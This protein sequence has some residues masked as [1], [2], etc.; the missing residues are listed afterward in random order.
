MNGTFSLKRF[1]RLFVKHTREHYKGYLMSLSV[2]IGVML[3]GGGFLVYMVN[4]RLDKGV[5]TVFF[6]MILLLAGSIFTSTVF[7][8]L[9]ERK[10]AIV[11]LTLP[12]S[13]FEKFLIAWIYSFIVF[14]V[15]YTIS[16]YCVAMFILNIKRFNEQP[17]G[18]LNIFDSR[19][20]SMYVIYAFLHGVALYGAIY[21]EKLHFIKTAFVFFI[22]VAILIFINKML[23]GTMLGKTVEAAPPF[24]DL[25][26]LENGQTYDLNVKWMS[27]T[28]ALVWFSGLL[29]LLLWTA[30]YYRLKEK[31]V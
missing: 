14:L 22:F 23:L 30:T 10:K 2:L 20:L 11:W 21:F 28:D 27:Q 3:L 4:A 24:A 17:G 13:H 15:V 25:R 9:G 18:I 8:D 7:A 1:T 31:Q 19:I 29:A 5:Q 12:A 16:F 26:F 6:L